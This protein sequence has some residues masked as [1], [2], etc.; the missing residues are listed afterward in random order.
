MC[1]SVFG[2]VSGGVNGLGQLL[3]S[4]LRKAEHSPS[5][6]GSA[7][8]SSTLIVHMSTRSW[9]LNSM[10][11][12]FSPSAVARARASPS[13][14]C[15]RSRHE[16][17]GVTAHVSARGYPDVRQRW[18]GTKTQQ[19]RRRRNAAVAA[20]CER[21]ALH[22]SHDGAATTHLQRCDGALELTDARAC[23]R[24]LALRFA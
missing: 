19:C 23:G 11:L 6:P 22:A 2:F 3:Q 1:V 18:E 4:R 8:L 14:A 24:Q 15:A 20:R 17:G 12:Y 13:A 16:D 21:R 5:E 9:Y 7:P 10:R